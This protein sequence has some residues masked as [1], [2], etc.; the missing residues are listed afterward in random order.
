MFE[1][2]LKSNLAIYEQV[3]NQI[4][5]CVLKGY[6]KEGDPIPS[7]R[8][9]STILNINPNTVSKAYQELERQGIIVTLR[10]K[11]TFISERATAKPDIHKELQK[12]RPTLA[13]LKIKGA[14]DKEI[15]ECIQ[16]ILTELK[17]SE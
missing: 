6:F 2:D 12:I 4:K 7:V 1:I 5:E 8:K 15:L 17:G 14:E 11:G 13:E 10:G 16:N 3:I 9:L